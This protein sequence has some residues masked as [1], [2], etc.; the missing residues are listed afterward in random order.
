MFETKKISREIIENKA[1]RL[2]GRREYSVWGLTKKLRKKFPNNFEEITNII[3]KF[4][5]KDWISDER[6]CDFM[7]REKAQ[8]SGWGERKIIMKL[9]EHKISTELI[10]EKIKKYF[11]EDIQ[12]K[13]SQKLAQEKLAKLN[14]GQKQLTEYEKKQKIKLFLVSRG[15]S[16]EIAQTAIENLKKAE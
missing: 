14:S 4:I 10:Q 15:F 9:R 8:Y 2:L 5:E 12:I 3:N 16:F 1:L 6:F 11:P 13:K 7:V